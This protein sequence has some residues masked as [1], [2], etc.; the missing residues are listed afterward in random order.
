MQIINLYA[1]PSAGKSTTAAY[2]F[3]ALKN[4]GYNVELVTEY[5]KQLVYSQRQKEMTNQVYLLAK[6]YKRLKDIEAYKQVPLVITDSPIDMGLVYAE[7]LSYYPQLVAL[8]T[9]LVSEFQN[10]NV[11]V[12]RT[13]KYN[14]SGRNQNEEEARALCTKIRC[15]KFNFDYTVEGNEK[16]QEEL[17]NFLA[18]KYRHLFE[19]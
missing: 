4:R 10:F 2:L 11:F 9:S 15:L 14:P 3:A 17:A 19:D 5:C 7:G 13:K 1:G 18:L 6:Q 8:T 12:E 16:G